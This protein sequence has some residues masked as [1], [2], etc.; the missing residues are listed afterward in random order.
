MCVLLKSQSKLA[1]TIKGVIVTAQI[2][3]RTEQFLTMSELCERLDISLP[4]LRRW[5]LAGKDPRA[6]KIGQTVRYRLTDVIEWENN[7]LEPR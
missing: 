7:H 4:T 6:F 1:K 5:R 2:S 3:E